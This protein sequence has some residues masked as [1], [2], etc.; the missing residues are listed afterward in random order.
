MPADYVGRNIEAVLPEPEGPI[1]RLYCVAKRAGD[2]LVAVVGMAP[3]ALIALVAG[4]VNTLTSP[5]PLF[6]HQTRVG[7]GGCVFRMHKFRTMVP[8]AE[9]ETGAVWAKE[10]DPRITP[11]GRVLRAIRLDE[12]PQLINI[13]CGEMSLIG[14]RPERPEFVHTLT[15]AIPYYRARC[16]MRPGITGWAQVRFGYG[17]TVDH[18]RIKLE[19]DLYYIRH[20][21]FYLDALIWLKT[22]A[23][24]LK[25]QGK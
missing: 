19:Y 23:M 6:F 11:A 2:T 25:L 24:M 17:N 13:L 9:V 18:A 1:H 15:S 22:I 8:D 20:A 5:G 12:L 7:Y 16:A 14:P 21:G 4:L 3:L 10:D